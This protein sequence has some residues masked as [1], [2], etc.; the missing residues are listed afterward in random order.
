MRSLLCRQAYTGKSMRIL[1]PITV[2]ANFNLFHFGDKHEGSVL[3][4]DKAWNK[5]CDVMNS[6]Y[7]GCRNN[8]GVNGG[9]NIEAITVDDKRFSEEKLTEPLPL[10]QAK[11]IIKKHE[12]IARMMLALLLGNHCRKLWR[13]GNLAEYI[14]NELGIPYGT[15]T[16]KLSF[17]DTKG[18]LLFKVYET[19]GFKSIT[20][21]ADDPKRRRTNQEIILKRHLKFKAADCVVMVKHHTHKLLVCKPDEDLFL[22]DDGKEIKQSYTGWGQ[23]ERYIHPDARWYGNAGSFLKLFGKGISGY[24]ELFEYDPVELGF[25]VTKVRDK[26]VK[27]IEPYYIKI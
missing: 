18:E 11:A 10:A 27:S 9:D 23:N 16:C 5:L 25:L 6:E 22:Y 12:P 24:A 4:S 17:V 1:P 3:S 13:F 15:Y 19:H 8:Y 26:K 20:S 14:A 21:T 2:P 7:D